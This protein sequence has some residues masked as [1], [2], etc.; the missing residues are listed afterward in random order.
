[1]TPKRN[2][3]AIGEVVPGDMRSKSG[4][5]SRESASCSADRIGTFTFKCVFAGKLVIIKMKLFK[6]IFIPT[7]TFSIT[8]RDIKKPGLTGSHI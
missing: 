7:D 3:K 8:K 6:V 5:G 4:V 1:M 2:G